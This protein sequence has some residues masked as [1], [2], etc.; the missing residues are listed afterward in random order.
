MSAC[1]LWLQYKNTC[2][3]RNA[4]LWFHAATYGQDYFSLFRGPWRNISTDASSKALARYPAKLR[5]F[6]KE[7]GWL[8]RPDYNRLTGEELNKF[9]I[10]LCGDD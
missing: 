3:E 1:T 7:N 8:E 6:I 2:V 4:T 9:G 10:S 5:A